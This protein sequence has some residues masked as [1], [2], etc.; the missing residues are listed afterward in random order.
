MPPDTFI[1][2]SDFNIW[3]RTLCWRVCFLLCLFAYFV[4]FLS[5]V[6]RRIF[7]VIR[8]IRYLVRS[9]PRTF[10]GRPNTSYLLRARVLFLGL[11]SCDIP[12]T[13]APALS[14]AIRFTWY[15]VS[16]PPP[17]DLRTGKYAVFVANS[18]FFLVVSFFS[19][20]TLF[21]FVV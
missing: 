7:F 21:V 17:H 20:S 18:C 9:P 13:F 5:R 2:A 19:C 16:S 4:T 8:F 1:G 15:P 11:F 14:W 12:L 6:S 3:S 10:C